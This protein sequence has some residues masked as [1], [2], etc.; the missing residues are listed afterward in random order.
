MGA[1]K[2]CFFVFSS[3]P[4]V[5]AHCPDGFFT[6]FS[7]PLITFSAFSALLHFFCFWLHIMQAFN[8]LAKLNYSCGLETRAPS[9]PFAKCPSLGTLF[10]SSAGRKLQH[11]HRLQLKPPK[12]EVVF[13]SPLRSFSL[14][15]RVIIFCQ[16]VVLFAVVAAFK[17]ILET[18]L[19]LDGFYSLAL[20]SFIFLVDTVGTLFP[21]LFYLQ[22][23]AAA[24]FHRHSNRLPSVPMP[25]CLC[26][27]LCNL[28]RPGVCRC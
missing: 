9:L 17:S 7:T 21:F 3:L 27:C 19:W 16:W 10:L 23:A 2:H 11:Q 6:P 24:A 12:L 4:S 28:A 18:S 15:Y 25:W 26:L 8:W 14:R 5:F 1:D 22:P 13:L 20:F